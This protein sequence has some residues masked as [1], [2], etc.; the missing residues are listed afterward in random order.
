MKYFCVE[1]R[2]GWVA[3]PEKIGGFSFPLSFGL[4]QGATRF[5]FKSAAQRAIKK[6]KLEKNAH[7]EQFELE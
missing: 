2:R 6:Y 4:L 3:I 7:V 5:P 1:S